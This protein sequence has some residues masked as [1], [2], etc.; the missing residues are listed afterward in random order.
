MSVKPAALNIRTGATYCRGKPTS[1][2]TQRHSDHERLRLHLG[3]E[4]ASMQG[5]VDV[6][7]LSPRVLTLSQCSMPSALMKMA[8]RTTVDGKQRL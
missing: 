2:C 4:L 8:L 7:R 6:V 1:V 3:N 5:L